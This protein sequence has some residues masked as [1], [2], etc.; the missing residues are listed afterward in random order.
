MNN[1]PEL[2]RK[3]IAA[4]FPDNEVVLT[5]DEFFI[6][7]NDDGSIGA[8]L[9]PDQ[10][11][12]QTFY[13]T[14]KGLIKSGKIKNAFVRIADIEDTEWFYSDT[15]YVVGQI[16]FDDLQ[17][18]LAGIQ[19]TEIYTGWMYDVPANLPENYSEMPEF[20]VWWD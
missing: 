16:A 7:N 13:E 14:F 1:R 9:Y 10:P 18:E 6:G 2:F 19:P 15:I 12:L 8:N 3:I 5:L 4:G 17:K 11:S 20:S